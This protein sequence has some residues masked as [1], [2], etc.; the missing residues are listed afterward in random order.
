[1]YQ[2]ASKSLKVSTSHG[3]SE[4]QIVDAAEQ[5]VA[6]AIDYHE[7]LAGNTPEHC[8]QP[9]ERYSIGPQPLP[10]VGILYQNSGTDTVFASVFVLTIAILYDKIL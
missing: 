2:S 7:T 3:P 8:R 5:K 9:R 10:E 1:M 4:T 6:T